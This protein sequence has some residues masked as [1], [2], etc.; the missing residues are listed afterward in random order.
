MYYKTFGFDDYQFIIIIIDLTS[1]W[2]RCACRNYRAIIVAYIIEEY[3]RIAAASR[4]FSRYRVRNQMIK[5][6]I[7]AVLC[8]VLLESCAS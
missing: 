4:D 2:H 6:Q 8:K 5:R 1:S 7:K 3:R